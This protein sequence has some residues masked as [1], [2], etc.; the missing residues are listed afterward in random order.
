MA[1]G[2]RAGQVHK[3]GKESA[4]EDDESKTSTKSSTGKKGKKRTS[5]STKSSSWIPKFGRK[6]K[7]EPGTDAESKKEAPPKPDVFTCND[8]GAK[9][10]VPCDRPWHENEICEEYQVRIK[11]R[12]AEE[13]ATLATMEKHTKK[14]P[15]CQKRIEKNGGCAHMFCTR[16][17]A[18]FCW[19]CVQ[20]IGANGRYCDCGRIPGAH[21]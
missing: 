4:A 9:A 14:C 21:G 13:D 20:V 19:N 10:C 7:T 6:M 2:C 18:Q 11:D 1:A 15:S 16:C 17:Q 8:C 3:S 12:I 5:T